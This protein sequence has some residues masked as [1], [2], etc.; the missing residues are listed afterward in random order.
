[1]ARVLGMEDRLVLHSLAQLGNR[2]RL[3]RERGEIEA[4]KGYL[5]SY[6]FSHTLFQ[7][8]LYR[9]LAPG[10]R[11]RLHIQVAETRA[12]LYSDD[13]DQV[14]VELAR[15]FVAAG[16]WNKAIPYLSRAGDLA[17]HKA[18]LFDAVR[19]YESAL[20][21]WPKSDLPGQ[22]QVMRKLGECLWVIGQHRKA[23]E[24]LND[25]YSLSRRAGDDQ[26]TGAAQRLLGRVYWELGQTDN[27]RDAY[28]QALI[29]LEH[30]P[31]SE[32][33]AWALEGMS[34]YHMHTGDYAELIKL[35]ERALAMAKRLGAEVI[36][37]QCLC[38]LGAARSSMGDWEGVAMEQ[39]SL[40]RALALNR[41]HDASRAY[42]YIAEA[43]KYLGRYDQVRGVL[44]DAISYTRRMYIPYTATAAANMLVEV[45]WLT[46]RWSTALTQLGQ[47][48]GRVDREQPGNLSQIYFGVVQGRLYNDLGQP[49]KS[50][51]IVGEALAGGAST[52]DP[53]VALLG[54]LARAEAALGDMALAVSTVSEI[55]EWTNQARYLFPSVAMALLT[56]CYMPVTFGWPAMGDAA[57]S[58]WT[59]LERLDEQYR[60]L[61]TT[62]CRLE[63][64]GWITLLERD[65]VQAT[66]AFQQ[67]Q[68]SWQEL[69]HPY[70]QVRALIGLSR[71]LTQD[72]DEFK[73]VIGQA[74][75]LVNFLDAQLEDPA[76]K[77]SFLA[78]V[79]VQQIQK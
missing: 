31:E 58:A 3:I 39:E 63:G 69:G 43:I 73:A 57:R 35:G 60:T 14:I 23:I 40:D 12:M 25:S 9:Q 68:T 65:E 11:R 24:L 19:H 18:S 50:R 27:A 4:G 61:V 34:A 32:E 42:L 56:I 48:F 16:D 59:Q 53:R 21:H 51:K 36:I 1:M 37:I 6:Q 55:L 75:G 64:L 78:S 70:D 10:E 47:Q 46:G 2:H 33:L 7:Q 67:A 30:K 79:L 20:V 15:H 76:L 29:I 8:Y 41:P 52:L 74:M 54:E 77:N 72:Q 45:D 17:Y 62:A 28:Q 5:S 38:D 26:G 71:A 22:A 66:A 49:E 44:E 13:L